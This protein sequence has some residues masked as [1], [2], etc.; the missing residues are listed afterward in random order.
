MH[1]FFNVKMY[2]LITALILS[3]LPS[4]SVELI[5][6]TGNSSPIYP[7]V[8]NGT[9]AWTIENNPI[10]KK[11]MYWNGS[12]IQEMISTACPGDDNS[13]LFDG[14]IAAGIWEDDSFS[15]CQFCE[16]KKGRGNCAGRPI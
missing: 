14:K 1:L 16:R 6:T 10:T 2:V 5:Q 8:Y 9:I 11:L 7:S 3:P 12:N 4:L 13:S 15:K